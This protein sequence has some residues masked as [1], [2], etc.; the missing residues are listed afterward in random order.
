LRHRALG[1]WGHLRAVVNG[2][3]GVRLRQISDRDFAEDAGFLLRP[4]SICG[5]AGD[6]MVF[7]CAGLCERD[8]RQ[9]CSKKQNGFVERLHEL[10]SSD[11]SG[12]LEETSDRG[13]RV[14]HEYLLLHGPCGQQPSFAHPMFILPNIYLVVVARNIGCHELD[15]EKHTDQ[16][17]NHHQEVA[18]I[19]NPLNQTITDPDPK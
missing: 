16:K 4:V 18:Y 10:K 7:G 15:D 12:A 3:G 2:F 13:T 19:E 17:T 8:D 1:P 14:G 9:K 6:G 5:R 11:D